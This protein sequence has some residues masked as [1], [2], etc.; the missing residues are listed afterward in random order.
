MILSIVA[1]FMG[2]LHSSTQRTNGIGADIMLLPSNASLFGGVG[3][4]SMPVKDAIAL[5][6]LP[7][8]A[9]VA[10]VIQHLSTSHNIE[11]V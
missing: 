4:A 7:H 2:M 1:V 10:P 9:V 6:Q 5:R 11:V 3:G 8:V